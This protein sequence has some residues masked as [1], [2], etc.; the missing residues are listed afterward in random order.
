VIITPSRK[1]YIHTLIDTSN[2]AHTGNFNATE[3]EKVLS[4]IGPKKFIA[5]VSDAEA[6]M[7]MARRLITEKYPNILSVHCMAHH[8]NLITT[9]LIKLNFA[10]S[11]LR[12]C[13]TIITFFKTSYRAS[14]S[15]QDDIIQSMT[16]GGGLK[17]SVKTRWSTA[18][19]CCDSIIRL[20]N[21]LKHVSNILCLKIKL[22]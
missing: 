22:V 21:S 3:I 8:L 10:K 4:S 13:Q 9:D 19:D 15:L 5:V 11:T 20:E 14:V 18:W 2:Q 17:T 16:E 7:Q 12:K 1:Q 6:A